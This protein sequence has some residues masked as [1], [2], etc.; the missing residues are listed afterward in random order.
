MHV[1]ASVWN[2][3]T[4]GDQ[5]RRLYPHLTRLDTACKFGIY[6]LQ[7][8]HI[9]LDQLTKQQAKKQQMHKL[10]HPETKPEAAV[11][12]T[13]S[14]N[15][16]VSRLDKVNNPFPHDKNSLS[17]CQCNK[18]LFPLRCGLQATLTTTVGRRPPWMV[19]GTQRRWKSPLRRQYQRKPLC[20]RTRSPH[21]NPER[22]LQFMEYFQIS[23]LIL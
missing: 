11:S 4:Q 6:S 16:L 12:E 22:Y 21:T 20:C 8:K 7:L 9:L 3:C 10:A 18:K 5:Y 19:T 23:A 1:S 17:I 2:N 13:D 14:S 15:G